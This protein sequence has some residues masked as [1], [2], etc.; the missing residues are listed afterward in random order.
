MKFFSRKTQG[1]QGKKSSLFLFFILFLLVLPQGLFAYL[2]PGTGSMLFSATLSLFVSVFF[3][4]KGLAAH[5]KRLILRCFGVKISEEKGR[6]IIIYSEGKTY[7]R[8]YR[9]LLKSWEESRKSGEEIPDIYYYSSDQEEEILVKDYERVQYRFIG[10]GTRAFAI[11]QSVEA[12]VFLTTTPDLEVLQLK[13]SKKVKHYA[14]ILHAAAGLGTYKIFGFDFFDSILCTGEHQIKSFRE[15]ERVRGTKP[16]KLLRTG[17]SYMDVLKEEKDRFRIDRPSDRASEKDKTVLIAPTWGTAGLLNSLRVDDLK[18][19]SASGYRLILR[20]HPQSFKVEQNLIRK[21]EEAFEGDERF[22]INRDLS[23]LPVMLESSVL[24]SDLSGII[25]DYYFI[26]EKPVI[27]IDQKIDFRGKEGCDLG[28]RTWELEQLDRIGCR[29]KREDLAD[30]PALVKETE[31]KT[32]PE[33]IRAFREANLFHFGKAGP[34]AAEQILEIYRSLE[35][36]PE[37]PGKAGLGKKTEVVL[38]A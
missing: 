32:D 24:I 2:D 25:F 11:L 35:S 6:K 19:L 36:E 28:N 15:L 23:P 20:P 27:T 17:C 13:R 18:Q 9:P 16:K 5:A 21:F 37:T 26:L 30:L 12:D 7:F 33:A 38:P 22:Q 8:V 31:K 34:V 10:A 1:T 29:I 4:L 14:H 3:V